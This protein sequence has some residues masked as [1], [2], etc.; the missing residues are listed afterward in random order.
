MKKY[1][2]LALI[3]LSLLFVTSCGD[4]KRATDDNANIGQEKSWKVIGPGGGGGVL[5][6]TV[7]PFNENF[8]L[9]HCDMTGVYITHDG[10]GTW[11]MRNLWNV[12]DDFEFDPSDS[13]TI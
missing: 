8:V 9:T 5:K 1:S 6:P 2:Q 3:L 4:I 13:A 11:K 10:G 7:S 12:P